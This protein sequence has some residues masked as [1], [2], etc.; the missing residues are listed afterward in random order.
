MA[1][2]F[3]AIALLKL[4][5]KDNSIFWPETTAIAAFGVAWLIKGQFLLKDPVA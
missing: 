3:I 4:S 1:L 5:S 2:S